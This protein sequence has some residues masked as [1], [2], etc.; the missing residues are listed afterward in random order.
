MA[1]GPEHDFAVTTSA[2]YR[3]V[4]SLAKGGMG[5]V[6]LVVRREGSFTRLYAL[7]RPHAHLRDDPEV[8]AM[9]MDEARV[10][11]LLRHPNVVSVVDIG[12]DA[13]GPFLVMDYVDGVSAGRIAS[14]A[15][16]KNEKVPLEVCLRIGIQVAE[17][18]YAA[19]RLTS[20]SGL[21]LGLVHRDV[22]PHNILVGY[23]GIARVSDFGVAKAIGAQNKTSTGI[24]KGK[25]G[26]MAPE[27]LQFLGASPHSDLFAFGVV[28]FELLT[29]ER[30]YTG[31]EGDQTARR[32]L[33]EPPPDLAD[34]RDDAPPELVELL[35]QLLAKLPEHRPADARIVARELENILAD[36][37]TG[38]DPPAVETSAYLEAEFGEHRAHRSEEVAAAV[39]A[40]LVAPMVEFDVD[41][42]VAA[43][44]R[45]EPRAADGGCGSGR[46]P[47]RSWCSGCGSVGT[48]CRG[49][50][51]ANRCPIRQR[52]PWRTAQ[53]E[54]G[55]VRPAPQRSRM[56]PGRTERPMRGQTVR[57]P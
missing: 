4:Q 25:L 42:A 48:R 55:N 6:N 13:E 2:S 19:H 54:R 31:G 28:L 30:L 52:P 46:S 1:S 36:F 8:V 56:W 44:A 21:L 34:Y 20:P 49:S 43:D 50:E 23:D 9:F 41:M 45:S 16:T 27:Q 14:N 57:R 53:L 35:F 17:G 26:Y 15:A 3:H 11:G 22:S 5:S 24:L 37:V 29:S 51:V 39:E 40:T 18:L 38:M 12:E 7:K 47:F 33:Q 10:A 32:I